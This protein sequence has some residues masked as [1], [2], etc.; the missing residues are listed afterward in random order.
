MVAMT[1]KSSMPSRRRKAEQ[2]K[3]A[4][5]WVY[6]DADEREIVDQAAAIQRRSTSS[7]AADAVLDKALEI[8]R[9]YNQSVAEQERRQRQG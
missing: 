4:A 7:F 9:V 5:I 6:M 8:I 1:K 3:N 2:K